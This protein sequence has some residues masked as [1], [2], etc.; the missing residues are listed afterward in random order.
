MK[1][2]IRIFTFLAFAAFT[3]PDQAAP[4]NPTSLHIDFQGGFQKSPITLLVDDKVVFDK[5]I[6]T[7]PVIGCAGGITISVS[8][9]SVVI[10]LKCLSLEFTQTVNLA[11]GK[12]VGLSISG[13][14]A[15]L[16]QSKT[17]FA[18]D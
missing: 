18:Y 5:T 14:K 11:A 3:L 9:D 6:S 10:I 17:P 1:H 8:K 7:N 2:L 15:I 16:T 13:N 4:P 12:Y